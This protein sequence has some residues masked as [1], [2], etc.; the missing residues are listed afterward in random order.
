[1][2]QH[3]SGLQEYSGSKRKDVGR[4][5]CTKQL[6]ERTRMTLASGARGR[7]EGKGLAVEATQHLVE[8]EEFFFCLGAKG[9]LLCLVSVLD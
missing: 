4:R 2:V 6:K 9:T 7:Y 1:M 3:T 5:R 8:G